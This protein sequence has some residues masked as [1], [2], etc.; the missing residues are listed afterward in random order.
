MRPDEIGCFANNFF[1]VTDDGGVRRDVAQQACRVPPPVTLCLSESVAE[2][3]L[4][5][6]FL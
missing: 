5:K 6:Y 2:S 4:G 1:R 3:A